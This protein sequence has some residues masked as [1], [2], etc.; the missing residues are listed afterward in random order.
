[1][2]EFRYSRDDQIDI[3]PPRKDSTKMATL[4]IK[5]R[6]ITAATEAELQ[7]KIDA[8]VAEDK[9]AEAHRFI[10]DQGKPAPFSGLNAEQA[11]QAGVQKLDAQY[12]APAHVSKCDSPVLIAL[13]PLAGQRPNGPDPDMA[14]A[15]ANRTAA[16]KASSAA[17]A[18]A[19]M[20][21]RMGSQAA[22]ARGD[23]S[24][25]KG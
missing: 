22:R 17:V 4:K 3:G 16:V 1:M 25:E 21:A 8:I 2:T 18:Q 9:L 19:H 13:G 24:K 11:R 14:A 15:E 6:T 23:L 10:A 20:V 7:A 5:G 12:K